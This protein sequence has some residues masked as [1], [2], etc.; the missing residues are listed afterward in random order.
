M[1]GAATSRQ[2]HVAEEIINKPGEVEIWQA[3]LLKEAA[4]RNL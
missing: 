4:Q 1:K 3:K 2:Q